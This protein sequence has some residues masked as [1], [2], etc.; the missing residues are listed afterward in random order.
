MCFFGGVVYFDID[1]YCIFFE[2]LIGVLYSGVMYVCG[3]GL[4]VMLIGIVCVYGDGDCFVV[5]DILFG[6]V[7]ELSD[8]FVFCEVFVQLVVYFDCCL[9][10]FDFLFDFFKMLC[11]EVLRV[12]I[13]VVGYGDIVSYGEVVRVIVLSFC[14]VGQVCVVNF[15]LIV[16]FCY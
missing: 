9:I 10:L 8:L 12:G 14:V 6:G 13:V 2:L 7:F 15:F 3:I 5:I 16:V 11:G 4:I 1:F